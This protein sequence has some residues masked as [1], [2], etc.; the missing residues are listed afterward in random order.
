LH[1]H[2]HSHGHTRAG[3]TLSA[4]LPLLPLLELLFCTLLR[5]A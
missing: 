4:L 5:A 1:S 2:L 3:F